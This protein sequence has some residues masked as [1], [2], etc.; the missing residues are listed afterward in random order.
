MG[1][2]RAKDISEQLLK[3]C[4]HSLKMVVSW[5]SLLLLADRGLAEQFNTVKDS[6]KCSVT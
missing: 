2:C 5:A 3:D 1:K 4:I 6:D